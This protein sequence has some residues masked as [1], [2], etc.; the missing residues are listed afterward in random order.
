MLGVILVAS[1]LLILIRDTLALSFGSAATMIIAIIAILLVFEAAGVDITTILGGA[2]ILGVAIAFGAQNLMRD[3]FN[4]FIILI[5]DQY[6]LNDLVT[7]N[8]ITG[9][10]E[11][12]S[13]RTTALRDLQGKRPAG[14]AAFHSQWRDQIRHEP[15]L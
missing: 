10:V 7:I 2:A 9:R 4:G 15:L 8:N 6:E 11:R 13:L 14:Q 5:E 1:V 3:Y 12:V